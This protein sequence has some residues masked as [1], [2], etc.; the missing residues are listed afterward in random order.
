MKAE[1]ERKNLPQGRPHQCRTVIPKNMRKSN[2]IQADHAAL[3]YLRLHMYIHMSIKINLW[4][5]RPWIWTRAKT[6]IWECLEVEREK[7]KLMSLALT[8]I[9][10][11]HYL[12]FWVSLGDCSVVFFLKQFMGARACFLRLC[13]GWSLPPRKREPQLMNFF[14]QIGLWT[15]QWGYCCN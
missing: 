5:N 8:W 4:K 9:F 15:S 2:T 11:W 14:L 1:S 13:S 10:Y 12:L 7:G 6:S 3:M